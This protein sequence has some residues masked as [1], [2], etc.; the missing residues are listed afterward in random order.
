MK[1]S[2]NTIADTYPRQVRGP[3]CCLCFEVK[4]ICIALCADAACIP[5]LL[6]FAISN[7]CSGVSH[8][9]LHVVLLSGLAWPKGGTES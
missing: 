1:N 2:R 8:T 7:Q 9:Y 6:K 3:W 5:F 4:H